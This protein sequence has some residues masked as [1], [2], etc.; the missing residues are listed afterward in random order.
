M[1][2]LDIVFMRQYE[3]A[4]FVRD[5]ALTPK[6]AAHLKEIR[7][8]LLKELYEYWCGMSCVTPVVAA[9][10]RLVGLRLHKHRG[11]KLW[12]IREDFV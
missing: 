2:D 12:V 7:P 8:N 5:T 3:L 1:N 4:G 9:R 11:K 10:L 6:E